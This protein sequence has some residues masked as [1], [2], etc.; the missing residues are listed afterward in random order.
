M[1]FFC[2]SQICKIFITSFNPT[3]FCITTKK[4]MKKSS[5]KGPIFKI[6]NE[7]CIFVW[8]FNYFVLCGSDMI[9][10]VIIWPKSNFCVVVHNNLLRGFPHPW[11]LLYFVLWPTYAWLVSN[12]VVHNGKQVIKA[13]KVVVL[14][15][16]TPLSTKCKK[17]ETKGVPR[18]HPRLGLTKKPLLLESSTIIGSCTRVLSSG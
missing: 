3:T 18:V 1:H 11:I 4:C 10:E 8:Y 2:V 5:Q 7:T 12:V 14:F 16:L 13:K 17:V 15:L 6:C 9:K